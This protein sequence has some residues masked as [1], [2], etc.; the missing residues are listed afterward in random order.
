MLLLLDLMS[1]GGG[2]ARWCGVVFSIDSC[3]GLIRSILYVPGFGIQGRNI[4]V[5][6][7]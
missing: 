1:V 2:S 5:M 7:T 4:L 6:Y 3:T